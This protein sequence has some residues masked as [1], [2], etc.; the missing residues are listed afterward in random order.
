MNLCINYIKV[1][2]I[3]KFYIMTSFPESLFISFKQHQAK[4]LLSDKT[5]DKYLNKS[6]CSQLGETRL[7]LCFCLISI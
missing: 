6:I 1:S 5:I 7:K 4:G 2:S 3:V